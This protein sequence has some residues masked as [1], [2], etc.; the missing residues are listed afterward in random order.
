MMAICTSWTFYANNVV[1]FNGT[2]RASLGVFAHVPESIG[3]GP[4]YL[5]FSP[6]APVPVP[7]P[8]DFNSDRK[9]DYVLY[10][11][12]TRQTAIWYLSNNVLIAGL[13]GPTLPV[14]WS[15]VGGADFNGDGKPDYLLYNPSTRQTAIWYL[16]NN[17]LIAGL[18]G[19][20]LP[21]GWSV[22]AP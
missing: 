1:R 21:A 11:P 4:A 16:S 15:V 9:P 10:N 20:T 2:T 19:P 6:R 18:F 13:F 3:T 17:V 8:T 22:V 14:G 12:S 7:I 5:A